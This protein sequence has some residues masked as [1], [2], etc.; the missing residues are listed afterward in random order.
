MTVIQF[1]D[2]GGILRLRADGHAGWDGS[3]HD[4]VCASESILAYTLL[5]NLQEAESRGWLKELQTDVWPGGIIAQAAPR[6]GY[7]S[8]VSSIYR[9]ILIGYRLLSENYPEYVRVT[10][11]IQGEKNGGNL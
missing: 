4:L 10:E 6:R 7:R 1:T 11:G 3:G 9:T 5:Q 8:A 2:R